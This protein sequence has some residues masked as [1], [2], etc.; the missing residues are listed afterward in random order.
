MKK[1]KNYLDDGEKREKVLLFSIITGLVILI[2]LGCILSLLFDF[3][4]TKKMHY[5]E[6][7]NLDYKVFLKENQFYDTPYLP[8]DKKYISALIN[9]I[10]SNFSYTFRSDDNINLKYD[11]YIDANL[12][13]DDPSG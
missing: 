9:Y 6:K 5:E 4:K 8:K 13:I 7:S 10:D 3:R 12:K 1:I 11:Y 2:V